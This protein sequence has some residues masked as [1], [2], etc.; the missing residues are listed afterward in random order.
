MCSSD[1][2]YKVFHLFR[3][4]SI[5]LV[6]LTI[7]SAGVSVGFLNPV[8]APHIQEVRLE[9]TGRTDTAL[10]RKLERCDYVLYCVQFLVGQSAVLFGAF[11]IIAAGLGGLL[12]PAINCA[13]NGLARSQSYFVIFGSIT[14]SVGFMLVGPA[15][16]L[17]LE[18]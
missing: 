15:P 18:K 3:A 9:G 13:I 7:L 10:I 11:F 14:I 5:P 4:R 8:L 17:T 12:A 2:G 1:L 16:F 6:A